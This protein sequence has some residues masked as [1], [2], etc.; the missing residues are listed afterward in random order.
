[1]G[2]LS[3]GY[4]DDGKDW[5]IQS[6]DGYPDATPSLTGTT[7]SNGQFYMTTGRGYV[8]F[9]GAQAA[10]IVVVPPVG[11]T[12]FSVFDAFGGAAG[13]NIIISGTAGQLFNGASTY[14]MST[15]YQ[16]ANFSLFSGVRYLGK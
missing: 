13:K 2:Y 6:F 16:Q 7:G 3:N 10:S 5:S 12:S 4:R 1:M 9:S 14:T 11:A 8:N 15:A